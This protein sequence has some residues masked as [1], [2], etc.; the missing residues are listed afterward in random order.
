MAVSSIT[1]IETTGKITRGGADEYN[2]TY[3]VALTDISAGPA[4]ALRAMQTQV[5]LG[6]RYRYGSDSDPN[7]QA[8]TIGPAKRVE[9]KRTHWRIP[10]RYATPT[11]EKNLANKGKDGRPTDEPTRWAKTVST[12]Q[13][14]I[15]R[16]AEHGILQYPNVLGVGKS[17]RRAGTRVPIANA[18]GEAFD[19]PPEIEEVINVYRIRGY[20][21]R[22]PFELNSHVG[23]VNNDRFVL[24][25]FAPNVG[26]VFSPLA[27]KLDSVN[28]AQRRINKRDVFEVE[29]EI[30]EWTRRDHRGEMLGWRREYLNQGFHMTAEKGMPDGRG[31]YFGDTTSMTVGGGMSSS[32]RVKDVYG[33][34]TARPVNLDHRGVVADGEYVKSDPTY[35]IYQIHPERQFGTLRIGS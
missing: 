21:S 9:G 26:F 15:S 18:A 2:V 1:T 28:V 32:V 13:R 5:K 19:P 35:I 30:Q 29:L 8:D 24:N 4:E 25:F 12:S 14:R 27:V 23:W 6:D 11:Y 31:G 20:D 17:A 16:V 7:A 22:F 3:E 33:N 10:I 34:A